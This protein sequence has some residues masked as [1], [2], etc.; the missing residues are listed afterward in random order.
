MAQT[1]LTMLLERS[2]FQFCSHQDQQN[3]SF[4]DEQRAYCEDQTLEHK[5]RMFT[6]GLHACLTEIYMANMLPYKQKTNKNVE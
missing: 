6:L 5:I 3:Q 4:L 2:Q 1:I